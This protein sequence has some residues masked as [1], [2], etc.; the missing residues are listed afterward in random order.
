MC[1][2]CNAPWIGHRPGRFWGGGKRLGLCC[3][4]WA[5][6]RRTLRGGKPR[7]ANAERI[8][9]VAAGLEL[10]KRGLHLRLHATP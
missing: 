9:E 3:N 4:C 6:V 5:R 1:R 8:I 7:G 10:R 2:A